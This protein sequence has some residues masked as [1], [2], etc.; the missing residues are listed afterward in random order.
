MYPGGVNAPGYTS[1]L[2]EPAGP[3]PPYAARPYGPTYN[4][5]VRV[6]RQNYVEEHR[7]VYRTH[8]RRSKKKSVAIVV[9]SAA[10]GAGIG[11]LAGGGKGAGI[12]ALAGGVGG[13]IYDR[14]THN[15]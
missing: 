2:Y 12:G 14:L 13:F 10:A 11:A 1:A 4:R 6:V 8:H 15:R 9:G 3:P 7:V 5:P